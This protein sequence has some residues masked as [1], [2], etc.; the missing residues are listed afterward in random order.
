MEYKHP[1]D[2]QENADSVEEIKE[3]FD[4]NKEAD[5]LSNAFS[6]P[7]YL[8][9]LNAVIKGGRNNL[10]Y[11]CL[12][13]LYDTLEEIDDLIYQYPCNQLHVLLDLLLNDDL[14]IKILSFS[15]IYLMIKKSQK[16]G[17]FLFYNT[18]IIDIIIGCI[19]NNPKSALT[20]RFFDVIST[21]SSINSNIHHSIIKQFPISTWQ[22]LLQVDA[23]FLQYSEYIYNITLYNPEDF[24]LQQHLL[25]IIH[26]TLEHILQQDAQQLILQALIN[27]LNWFPHVEADYIVLFNIIIKLFLSESSKEINNIYYIMQILSLL[28]GNEFIYQPISFEEEFIDLLY[29]HC[30]QIENQDKKI[31]ALHLLQLMVNTG[32]DPE[33]LFS[34][35]IIEIVSTQLL[36]NEFPHGIS[37]EISLL[38]L[39]VFNLASN[40]CILHFLQSEKRVGLFISLKLITETEEVN[41]LPKLLNLINK[42]ISL[43]SLQGENDIIMNLINVINE[44]SLFHIKE[45]IDDNFIPL[46]DHLIAT[47]YGKED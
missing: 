5:D 42:L 31:L 25:S 44:D 41:H 47:L 28:L 33:F 22:Q 19:E 12:E 21:F 23:I 26:H 34:K 39:T 37:M 4:Q 9:I 27:I 29:Q 20:Y 10:I 30:I 18:N 46:V 16:I 45:I 35:N 8:S 6:L 11:Q 2:L 15:C 38:L 36:D 32:L 7:Q 43:S 1:L 14:D 40:Q 13:E 3:Y 24:E 17:L